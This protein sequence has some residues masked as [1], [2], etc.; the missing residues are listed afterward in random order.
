MAVEHRTGRLTLPASGVAEA[1]LEVEPR[2]RGERRLRAGAILLFTLA[3]APA[4]FLV[5]PHFL[6]PLVVLAAGLYLVRREWA[7]EYVVRSFEGSCPRCG[8]RLSVE[9]GARIRARQ[10]LECYGCHREPQL[11]LDDPAGAPVGAGARGGGANGP[12]PDSRS[13]HGDRG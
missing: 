7:G 9:A 12:G 4:A 3:V 6:W 10:R 8:E 5:P 11:R 1:S 13:V 2:S